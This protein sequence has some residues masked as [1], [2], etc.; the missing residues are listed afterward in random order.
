[1]GDI[2]G[3]FNLDEPKFNPQIMACMI[4]VWLAILAC[5]LASINGQSWTRR[6]RIFWIAIVT[7]IPF[8]GVLMYLPFSFRI[9][10]YPHLKL[11]KKETR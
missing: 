9:E 10:N 3:R 1:M 11:L 2:L 6:Q 7:G 4:L 8:L 5:S